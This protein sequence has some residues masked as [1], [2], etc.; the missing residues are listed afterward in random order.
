[1]KRF[2]LI[3]A[4]FLSILAASRLQ[5][6]NLYAYRDSVKNGYNFLLYVPDSYETSETP[7]P[8]LLCL[9]GKSLAGTET[10]SKDSYTDITEYEYK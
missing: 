5:A 4:F 10:I 9:H 6:D 7:L 1:M 2:S 3:L 8:I